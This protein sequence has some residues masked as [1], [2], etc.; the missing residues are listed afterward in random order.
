M[1]EHELMFVLCAMSAVWPTH[2]HPLHAFI[3][4]YMYL[5][6]DYSHFVYHM[7]MY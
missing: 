6:H 3:L 1:A 7:C 2:I 4:R 5:F